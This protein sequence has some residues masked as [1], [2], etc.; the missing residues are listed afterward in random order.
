[1][2]DG[3]ILSFIFA[4][5]WNFVFIGLTIGVCGFVF[6]VGMWLASLY[7]SGGPANWTEY[8]SVTDKTFAEQYKGIKIPMETMIEAY[9][10][11]KIDFKKDV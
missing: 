2:V 9:L 1:M 4:V 10:D 3:G 7:S 8:L 6:L 5:V 11:E